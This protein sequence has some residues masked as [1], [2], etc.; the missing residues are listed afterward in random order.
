VAVGVLPPW[1][2]GVRCA[3]SSQER[4]PASRRRSKCGLNQPEAF[5][6]Q[7]AVP[8][9][10]VLI[11]HQHQLSGIVDSGCATGDACLHAAASGQ[12]EALG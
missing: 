11:V 12:P 3:D 4:E 8:Q 6:D 5:G 1:S 10:A 7:L 2:L 9:R